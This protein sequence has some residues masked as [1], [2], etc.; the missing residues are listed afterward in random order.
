MAFHEQTVIHDPIVAEPTAS[1][2]SSIISVAKV[3][4]AW[5][6]SCADYWAAA[7]LYDFLRRLSDSR[8]EEARTFAGY[9]CPG[10]LPFLPLGRV[11][12]SRPRSMAAAP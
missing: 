12:D 2:S 3:F 4:A 1:L 6:D 5:V 9:A 8:A 11:I 10:H 7:A